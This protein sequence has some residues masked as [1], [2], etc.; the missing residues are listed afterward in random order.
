M[1]EVILKFLDWLYGYSRMDTLNSGR[2]P[3]KSPKRGEWR[4]MGLRDYIDTR[5][6]HG[7]YPFKKMVSRAGPRL[8]IA[9]HEAT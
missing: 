9:A 7:I 5:A 3:A 1:P 2:D 6:R 4:P 8:H